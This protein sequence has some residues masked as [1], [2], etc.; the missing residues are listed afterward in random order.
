MKNYN[1][2]FVDENKDILN[3]REKIQNKVNQNEKKIS[4]WIAI[5][6]LIASFFLLY[7]TYR[8]SFLGFQWEWTTK[9]L[10]ESNLKICITVCGIIILMVISGVAY[11]YITTL[12]NKTNNDLIKIDKKTLKEKT[13]KFA[14]TTYLNDIFSALETLFILDEAFKKAFKDIFSKLEWLNDEFKDYF[15]NS[16][17]YYDNNKQEWIAEPL[18][19]KYEGSKYELKKW[20]HDEKVFHFFFDKINPNGLV[21]KDI[22]YRLPVIDEH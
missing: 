8:W 21:E 9:D 7:F 18:I 11:Y 1:K 13:G 3:H 2:M 20:E 10:E 22:E 6:W 16:C 12:V 4:S 17:Y 5:L 15:Y 14:T 19:I